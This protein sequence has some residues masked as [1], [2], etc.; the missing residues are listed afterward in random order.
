MKNLFLQIS[1]EENFNQ[2]QERQHIDEKYKW[3]LKDIYSS[4]EEW[5]A[6]FEWVLN[7][8][9]KY[10]NF[11]GKLNSSPDQL[12]NCLKFDEEIGCKLGKLSLYTSLSKDTDLRVQKYQAY[13]NKVK[14]LYYTVLSKSSFIKIEI[15]SIDPNKLK[16]WLTQNE[17]LKIYEHY[18]ENIYRE[19]KH[20]LS[21]EIEAILALSNDISNVPYNI[22]LNLVN[23]DFK[24]PTIKDDKGNDFQLSHGKF[25]SALYSKNRG[26]RADAHKSF[27]NVFKEF[28][29]SICTTFNGNLKANIFYSK[30]RNFSSAL[31]A[32]LFRDNIPIKLYDNLIETVNDNLKP[33][34]RWA[35]LRAKLLNLDKIY[36]YD[37][38]VSLFDYESEKKYSFEESKEILKNSFKVLGQDYI[39]VLEKAFNE[40]WID[41][42]ET[43]GKRS[44]AYSSGT[45]Y[46]VH[47]YVLLNWNYRLNDVFTFA[48]EMGHNLHSYFTGIKQPFIYANYSIFLAEIASTLNEGLLLDYL[49]NYSNSKS[50]KVLLIEKYL[51]NITTTFYRQVMFAEFEKKVYEI[52]ENGEY[53]TVDYLCNLYSNLYKKYWGEIMYVTEEESYTWA[54][55][56]HFYYNFYVFQYA[57]GFAAAEL[58]LKKIKEEGENAIRN[59]L[60][61]LSSGSHK[62][63]ID[64]L[65]EIGIDINSSKPIEAVSKKMSNLL[66]EL[67][68]LIY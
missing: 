40:R 58:I 38:Y 47:P 55:I 50:E 56:P 19:K 61:F 62:Y 46:G 33:M 4:D 28:S 15:Q 23:S 6:D 35:K 3:N 27:M 14:N 44:G 13:D 16:K 54:R 12:L 32:A 5:E 57:T 37:T 29:N 65:Y 26:F 36:P 25:Y 43:K 45:T 49:I 7:N 60:N 52:A 1:S 8:Y 68:N 24:F 17:E 66:D 31:E 48:H 63:S 59:Y 9:K 2:I 67:E 51:N 34:H 20:T 21:R 64:L 10:S 42:F 30:V 53:L 18:F 39:N 22:F 41:V 11:N